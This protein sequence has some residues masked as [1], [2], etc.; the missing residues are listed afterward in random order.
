MTKKMSNGV[1]DDEKN[2]NRVLFDSSLFHNEV[3]YKKV[4]KVAIIQLNAPKRRNTMSY[5]MNTGVLHALE[6]AAEDD[7]VAVIILT[8]AGKRAFC[9]GGNLESD[10]S[11]QSSASA[12]M[13]S[14][15]GLPSTVLGSTRNLRCSMVTSQLLRQIP[16]PTICA[17]N[18]ACAGAG[19]SWACACD[20][21]FAADNALFRTGFL[22]AGLSGG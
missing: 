7:Q 16:K 3:K 4:K 19:M 8:G 9:A 12:G 21:R 17:V 18:G 6:L 10:E 22:S 1:K 2:T 14:S 11:G 20:I 15:G 5:A 13:R